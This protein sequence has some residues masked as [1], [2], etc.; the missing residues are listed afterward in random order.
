MKDMARQEA[1]LPARLLRPRGGMIR[2]EAVWGWLLQLPVL[3]GL[4]V[5]VAGP[6]IASLVLAFMNWEILTPPSFV[7]LD[8]VNTLLND[9]LFV[10]AIGNTVYVTLISVPLY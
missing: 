3:A 8:N 6:L 4:A 1:S 2:E 5:F 7:G 9:P 10:R